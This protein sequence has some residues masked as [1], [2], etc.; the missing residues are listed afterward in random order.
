M[1]MRR[2]DKTWFTRELEQYEEELYQKLNNSEDDSE[3]HIKG[4]LSAI[5]K[6][7]LLGNQLVELNKPVIPEFVAEYLEADIPYSFEEKLQYLVLSQ[8]GDHYY[9]CTMLPEDKYIDENLGERVYGWV[10]DQSL[11]LLFNLLNG[12]TTEPS[13]YYVQFIKSDNDSFLGIRKPTS[14]SHLESEVSVGSQTNDHNAKTQFTKDEIF[15]INK[16]FWHFRKS[17]Y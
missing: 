11:T 10:Q 5:R 12:Y 7:R 1:N 9:L 15:E 17:V 2:K 14:A 8:H 6:M 3:L 13:K 4:S 16:D